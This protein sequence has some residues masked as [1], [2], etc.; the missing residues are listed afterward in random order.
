[1]P[2]TESYEE[3]KRKKYFTR[4]LEEK[5][6][7][8]IAV[9]L[10]AIL[11]T[12]FVFH[13]Y[14]V[15][16]SSMEHTFQDND[17]LLVEKLGKTSSTLFRQDYVPKRYDVV[18]FNQPSYDSDIELLKRVVGLPGDRVVI[19]D[20]K[21]IVYNQQNPEGVDVNSS[22]PVESR[23]IPTQ[24]SESFD[25]KV[26]EGEVFVLGD[27]RPE[28]DDSRYFGTIETKNIV[29]KAVVRLLPFNNLLI[30]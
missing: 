28:S 27:N 12:A 22:L 8:I 6:V 2:K 26:G 18:V 10:L 11:L 4:I 3:Q 16:G 9:P 24:N 15:D 17:L 5:L 21:I 13:L 19:K 25:I 7:F 20:K 1:M 14:R 30:L 23:L 29:G